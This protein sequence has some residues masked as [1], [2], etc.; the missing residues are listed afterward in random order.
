MQL[1]G[2]KKK[3]GHAA[4]GGGK[5][6]ARPVREDELIKSSADTEYGEAPLYDDEDR[7][8]QAQE[9]K[10]MARWLKT[11]LIV[12]GALTVLSAVAVG[13]FKIWIKAPDIAGTTPTPAVTA[14]QESEQV[15]VTAK[16]IETQ[17]PEVIAAENRRPGTYT[18]AIMGRD[19]EA[20]NMD[21]IIVGMFDTVE[22]K[23]NFAS[24]PRDTLINTGY[25]VKKPNYIYPACVNNK[26][27]GIA[28]TLAALKDLLG[29]ELDCYAVVDVSA[30]EDIIDA[31][32]GVWFDV[33]RDMK[34]DGWDQ[35]P[36]IYIDIKKGY[37]LLN[38]E[39]FVKVAR[40]RYTTNQWGN[41]SGGYGGGDIDRIAVQHDLLMAAMEQILDIGNIPN[42]SKAIDIYEAKVQ[43]NLTAR[44]LGYFAA[45]FLKMDFSN[46]TFQ[47]LPGDSSIWLYET[48][49]VSPYIDQWLEIVNQYLNPYDVAITRAN[50]NMISYDAV[51][52]FTTTQGYVAGGE[53][54]FRGAMAED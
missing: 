43:T 39:D 47:T 3:G 48:S 10:G 18:F 51:N 7:L 21:T 36:P 53:F 46:I 25:D 23:L 9:K 13:V 1:F 27:D 38:G 54:S 26:K 20:N 8:I 24:I 33:P 31:I 52:G 11:V 2:G 42:L 41:I 49:Y 16:P 14:P 34:Y 5:K 15:E 50:V 6:S 32:G 35:K 40:F 19:V 28:P 44:N 22:G 4:P 12:L 45:E 37:Q 29:Y 30:V 17:A